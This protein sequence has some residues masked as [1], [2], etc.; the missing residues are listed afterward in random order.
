MLAV[1]VKH[2]ASLDT[3]PYHAPR[4]PQYVHVVHSADYRLVVFKAMLFRVIHSAE[5][6]DT[7]SAP[8]HV[9]GIVTRRHGLHAGAMQVMG[10][11]SRK[12]VA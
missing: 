4:K 10:E 9:F 7:L 2:V 8:A 1:E 6:R 5:H 12:G 11:S 3:L